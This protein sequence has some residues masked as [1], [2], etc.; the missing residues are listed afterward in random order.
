MPYVNAY[1]DVSDEQRG[2]IYHPPISDLVFILFCRGKLVSFF[3]LWRDEKTRQKDEDY[4]YF[5]AT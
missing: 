3:F 5:A 1:Y 2:A 4:C